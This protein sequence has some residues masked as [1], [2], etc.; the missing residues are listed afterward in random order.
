MKELKQ[1]EVFH[2]TWWRHNLSW[3][4]GSEPCAGK[5]HHICFTESESS[6]RNICREWNAEHDPGELSDKAEYQSILI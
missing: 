3:P 4:N 6:A 5:K 1:F 2:R